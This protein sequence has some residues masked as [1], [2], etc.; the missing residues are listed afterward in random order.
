MCENEIKYKPSACR[1]GAI[2]GVFLGIVVLCALLCANQMELNPPYTETVTLTR[3]YIGDIETVD[4][5]YKNVLIMDI[6]KNG[7]CGRYYFANEH[8]LRDDLV[9]GEDIKVQWKCII[10]YIGYRI[11]NIQP[12]A[13]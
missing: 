3:Q 7:V 5:N 13:S 12:V 6:T 8:K 2:I 4:G 10:P 1:V 9:V 11:R